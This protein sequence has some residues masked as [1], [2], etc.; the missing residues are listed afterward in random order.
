MDNDNLISP[1]APRPTTDVKQA[2]NA[3]NSSSSDE[4]DANGAGDNEQKG[5]KESLVIVEIEKD[6][7]IKAG[8]KTSR[9][10]DLFARKIAALS[11]AFGRGKNTYRKMDNEDDNEKEK[12][13]DK[14]H[15]NK[16]NSQ[17]AKSSRLDVSSL[18]AVT[19]NMHFSY[20]LGIGVLIAGLL[21]AFL[22]YNI[23]I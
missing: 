22:V 4:S 13:K 11:T 7:E 5:E 3:I 15:K 2:D 16:K 1:L 6:E 10:G 17:H 12:E 19:R 14:K 23:Y 21:T 8:P 20:L 9:L 18:N